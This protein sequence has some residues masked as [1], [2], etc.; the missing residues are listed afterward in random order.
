VVEPFFRVLVELG[1]DRSIPPWEPTPARLIPRLGA[2]ELV[3]DL[4]NAIRE[5]INNALALIGW[6]TRLRVRSPAVAER[7]AKPHGVAPGD[8]PTP[9]QRKGGNERKATRGR[10]AQ[11]VSAVTSVVGNGRA[12]VRSAGGDNGSTAATASNTPE[13]G[14]QASNGAE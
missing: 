14:H 9:S 8:D 13:R 3:A 6:P 7:N 4:I 1:Y 11:T 10:V 2:S 5:G 12:T